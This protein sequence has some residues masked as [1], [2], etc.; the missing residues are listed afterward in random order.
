M[1]NLLL[2]PD[3]YH[4][5]LPY[6]IQNYDFGFCQK[7]EINDVL[8]FIDKYWKKGHAMVVSRQLMDWQHY[9]GENERYLFSIARHKASNEIHALQ[10]FIT[11]NHFDSNID[12]S[13]LWGAIWKTREDVAMPG[14]GV[15]VETYALQALDP[16]TVAGLGKSEHSIKVSKRHGDF[17]AKTNRYFILNDNIS[18]F[19]LCETNGAPCGVQRE[20]G[21]DAFVPIGLEDY[22]ACG[23]RV[24][25][26]LLP[27][28]SKA[29][30]INRYFRHPIYQ[31][32]VTGIKNIEGDIT[33]IFFWRFCD[34]SN[35]KCIRIV[36]YIGDGSEL[37]GNL[38][39]FQNLLYETEA[40]FVDFIQY[41]FPKQFFLDGGWVDI[42]D[43]KAILAHYFEPFV[44]KN[45]ELDFNF[46]SKDAAMS[47]MIFKGDADQD[48]PNIII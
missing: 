21:N 38:H 9:D 40:E 15:M 44:L 45:I 39:N 24:F 34:Y 32:N 23:G 26:K 8:E 27:Y 35:A 19:T 22:K 43:T 25:D 33:A 47:P 17:V 7:N 42:S 14:L 6:F 5:H 20:L 3:T 28:K 48:R 46:K 16:H 1:K 37:K 29:Y 11:S 4:K 18:S 13:I 41:G 36:D 10:G 2:Y 31:Y 30:Y 12:K